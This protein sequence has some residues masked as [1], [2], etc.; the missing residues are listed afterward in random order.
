MSNSS[1]VHIPPFMSIK[2][3][4]NLINNYSYRCDYKRSYVL[5][6]YNPIDIILSF[7]G[8]TIHHSGAGL[9]EKMFNGGVK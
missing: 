1:N 7:E 9:Q 6:S 8:I 5:C 2:F 4:Y 3:K